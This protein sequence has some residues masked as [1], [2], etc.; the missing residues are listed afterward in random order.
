MAKKKKAPPSN[1]LRGF[2]T[3]SVPSKSKAQDAPAEP[4]LAAL[5]PLDAEPSPPQPTETSQPPVDLEFTEIVANQGPKVRR[6]SARLV[7]NFEKDR[8]IQRIGCYPLRV[9]RALSFRPEKDKEETVGDKVLRLARSELEEKSRARVVGGCDLPTAWVVK[10]VLVGLGYE[11]GQVDDA[12]KAVMTRCGS[13]KDVE[14]IVE[15][16]IEWGAMFWE[17]GIG[18][19][20]E[21]KKT[22]GSISTTPVSTGKS[23]PVARE[24]RVAAPSKKPLTVSSPELKPTIPHAS[25]ISEILNLGLESMDISNRGSDPVVSP[26]GSEDGGKGED[27]EDEDD[28]AE[29]EEL[30]PENLVPTY[31]ALQT[32]LYS[33]HP[34]CA[35]LIVGGKKAKGGGKKPTKLPPQPPPKS[36]LDKSKATVKRLQQKLEELERDPLFDAHIAYT[37]WRD[38]RINLDDEAWVNRK[39]ESLPPRP[40]AKSLAKVAPPPSEDDSLMGSLFDGPPT[41]EQGEAGENIFI[42]DFEEAPAS[43]VTSGF[44]KKT[45]KGKAGVGAAAMKKLVEEICKNRDINSKVR[46]EAISGT[47]VS[48]RSRLTITWSR[49]SDLTPPPASPKEEQPDVIIHLPQDNIT[50]FEMK[51]LAAATRD[52]ADGF[53]VTYALHKL[54]SKKENL[55][56]RLPTVWRNVWAELVEDDNDR[57]GKEDV[58][59]LKHLEELLKVDAASSSRSAVKKAPVLPD[60]AESSSAEGTEPSRKQKAFYREGD[61]IKEEWLARRSSP[62]FLYME[63]YRKTLPMWGF[64]EKVLKAVEANPVVVLSGQTGC[65]KSTQL[66]TFLLEHELENGRPCKIYCTQPRRISAISLARRVAEEMGEGKG[67]V[68]GLVGYA[69]RLENTVTDRTR[70]IYATTGIVMRMLERST[71]LSDVTHLI[72]DEVHERSIESDFLMVVLKR[73]LVKRKDLKVVL[74]SATLDAERF[75]EYLGG[76]P[77][78]QVPGRT[79]PVQEFFLE[80]AIEATGYVAEDD[81]GISRHPRNEWDDN[82]ADLDAGNGTGNAALPETRI[83]LSKLDNYRI[84]YEL[85]LKLL[86]KIATSPQFVDYS[87]AILI[88]LPGLREIR[89]LND[90]ILSHPL[91]G[92]HGRNNRTDWLIYPLH[93]TIASEEQEQAF[94]IPPPGMRKIVLA[95]NIAET[96]ITIPD[97]TAVIDTGKHK[98]M[99]FDERRQLSRLI[100]T[101]ISRANANQRRGRAGRVRP[102]ICWHLFTKERYDRFMPAQ[103][104]PEIMRLSLQD[105]VLRVKICNLGNVEEV[106]TSALDSPTPKNIKRAV[107]SLVDVKALTRDEELTPLGMQLAKLPLDVYLGKLVL[108]GSIFGCLDVALTVAA[109]LSSKSPFVSPIGYGNEAERARL[110]FRRGDSDL[111]TGFNAYA[112]W[113]RVCSPKGSANITEAE[114]C[115][116]NFISSRIMNGIEDLKGQ[117][118]AAA[119]D[120]GFLALTP[121]ERADFDRAR[122]QT[123]YR[124]NFFIVPDEFNHNS[125]DDAVCSAVVA[126]AFYPKLLVRDG[127]GWKNVGGA[128]PVKVH[129]SS[130]NWKTESEWLSYYGIMRAGGGR[131]SYDA[132][133]TGHVDEL[134]IAL[135]CGEAEFKVRHPSDYGNGLDLTMETDISRYC[136]GGRKQGPLYV[137]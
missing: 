73:L 126:A 60:G 45:G 37:A 84:P 7:A 93:S 119:V 68:G 75:S 100:E 29:D 16:C 124:S 95:T 51:K 130:V 44:A 47:L 129:S 55:S 112:V 104:T 69:I 128:K 121:F 20:G 111:L 59:E 43:T 82:E 92:P 108:L 122:Y 71:E 67:K 18:G 105:L 66:P 49:P 137:Q 65:G 12:V 97:I 26:D 107:D 74:M 109:L 117:L 2:A 14:S 132:H 6:E 81:P 94:L 135:L 61:A 41:E 17:G 28:G 118:T 32:K 15:E 25:P 52:Q 39:K 70:L 133:D 8:R 62:A 127:R 54:F 24:E 102:G 57:S 58:K 5:P 90:M 22:K 83:T 113:R 21:E 63:A 131:K 87:K 89:R 78:L 27:G 99:L 101:F 134:V 11:V 88:F 103:Q 115:R 76:A 30:T 4:Q 136:N 9:E 35:S 86:E 34:N 79:F 19:F 38:E 77:V 53:I 106:L 31:L 23:T 98:V 116:K 120:A 56:I 13:A 96:G 72:L 48:H 1:P 85:I 114:F 36:L 40:V 91:F 64:R 33:I 50:V 10:R 110:A 3:T 123:Y 46:F 125:G 80:D 42:R